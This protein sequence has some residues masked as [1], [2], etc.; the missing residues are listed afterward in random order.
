MHRMHPKPR[1]AERPRPMSEQAKRH[2]FLGMPGYG[3]CTAAAS[4]GLWRACV[5]SSV[6]HTA[7]HCGSLLAC[8]F[9]ALWCT[10]LNMLRS[11]TPVQYFAMLHDDIGPDDFWLDKL[12]D[13]LERNDLDVLG[14][15]IPIKDHK[16]LTSLAIDHDSGDPWR[17]QQRLTL[18]EVLRLP[19]TF[20]SDDLPGPLLLNTGCWVCRFDPD[21][22]T[23]VHFEI[24]DRIVFD[25]KLDRFV[26]QVEPEDWFF[27]RLC[28]ER[29]L[30]IGA[31]RI[32]R[33]IHEGAAEFNNF[34]DWGS[35]SFD[36]EYASEPLV[37]QAE[38]V[39]A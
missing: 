30:A 20:T 15:A 25:T 11:G 28:H 38:S 26:N 33:A 9:N 1:R 19:E 27:S 8:N 12:I 36:T 16:G 24:N 17:I 31:T 29:G 2:V 35:Q 5:D 21:W 18:S 7:Y 10:A 32:V 23:K 37:R 13:E 14:V 6:V 39:T 3:K 22:V 4:R 34:H